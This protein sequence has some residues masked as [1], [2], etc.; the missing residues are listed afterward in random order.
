MSAQH[1][2]TTLQPNHNDEAPPNGFP[3]FRYHALKPDEIRLIIVHAGTS[4]QDLE[5]SLIDRRLSPL[6]FK[7]RPVITANSSTRQEPYEALSYSWDRQTPSNPIRIRRE[8]GGYYNFLITDNLRDA[9]QNLRHFRDD[10]RFWVDAI[11]I[12]QTSH[13]DKN[14]Q[15]PLM[16]RIY[17]EAQNVCI[18]LGLED[19]NTI[20]AFR[21]MEKIRKLED[22]KNVVESNTKCE[23]WIAFHNLIK[24]TW[25][26]RRWVVQEITMARNATIYCGKH[27]VHW[28][29]FA[30]AIGLFELMADRVKDM[31]RNDDR[32]DQHPDMFG[33]TRQYSAHQLVDIKSS[34]VTTGDDGQ[35]VEKRWSLESLVSVLTS[36]QAG[37]HHD[38]IYAV[39]S[40]AKD[41]RG[42][43]SQ[44]PVELLPL[45][46][47][48]LPEEMRKDLEDK[49]YDLKRACGL[50]DRVRARL[51]IDKYP[52]DYSKSF[53]QVCRDFYI[54]TTSNSRSLDIICRPWAPDEFELP[55][56]IRT[57]REAPFGRDLKGEWDRK[58]ADPL[59]GMP[60]ESL[61]FA[62]GHYR[63]MKWTFG[64]IDN[65]ILC[66]NGFILDTIHELEDAARFA[67]VPSEWLKYG[68]LD[69]FGEESP[70]GTGM[71]RVKESFWRTMVAGKGP[72]GK[73]PPP[74]YPSV[75]EETFSHAIEYGDVNLRQI[76]DRSTNKL[77]KDFIRRV[78]AVIWGRKL[79][80]TR[81]HKCLALVPRQAQKGDLICILFGCSVPVV[82]RRKS[83]YQDADPRLDDESVDES[84][85][86]LIGESYV[87]RMMN[88]E[89]FEARQET[90]RTLNTNAKYPTFKIGKRSSSD[91]VRRPAEAKL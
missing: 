7:G 75:C 29:A 23:E 70:G 48:D 3:K 36:F 46:P 76:H 15:L 30:E 43:S 73:D 37:S 1:P 50:L 51:K 22:F 80:E 71:H 19:A 83:S 78:K 47:S 20:A 77:Q 32:Y 81:L 12:D 10:R 84:E 49:G 39:L 25:F 9:L 16:A 82:L 27:T 91:W 74:F 67:V 41:V 90:R 72:D 65:P 53:Y 6:D 66:A 5:C 4:A 60:G 38:I 44:A 63:P 58:N 62:S 87:H 21:L 85:F 24:K 26:S 52:V 2:S 69:G 59:V 54:F 57:I 89:A 28:K 35:V 42:S 40:L 17:T 11:C 55:S 14:Q 88:G 79:T 33:E 13:I 61:Y 68:N 31:F 18:S 64:E 45:Q 34:I 8:G 56:W 86:E